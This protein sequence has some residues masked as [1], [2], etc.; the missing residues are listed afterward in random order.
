MLVLVEISRYAA[1]VEALSFRP[2]LIQKKLQTRSDENLVGTVRE[3]GPEDLHPSDPGVRQEGTLPCNDGI[4]VAR[5]MSIWMQLIVNSIIAGGIYSLVAIGYTM[6]YG[7]LK[8]IN[9]A[10]GDLAMVGAYLTFLFLR[11][12][13]LP[14]PVSI[15]LSIATVVVLG[16][17]IEKIAYR[18]LRY[19]SRLSCLITAIAVSLFLQSVVIL[20][21]GAKTRIFTDRAAHGLM[22]L[23]A[24]ITP[25]QITI[26]GVSVLLMVLLHV[27]IKHAK[28]GKAMRAASDDMTVAAVIGIDVDKVISAVF[29]IGSGLAC[30]AGILIAWETNFNPTMGFSI[31]IKAFTAAVLGGI[32]SIR[33]AVLGGF[34]IGI[35]ENFGI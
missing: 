3:T 25:M 19:A 31:G 14:L 27:F 4:E 34:I 30:V 13:N 20:G 5:S 11:S 32:G 22:F 21:F 6:V 33:G 16:I 12:L 17:L 1:S 35:S 29:A 28:L 2:G 8:F 10:H 24:Y 15:V 9:F 26:I 23:G 7:V 18:P